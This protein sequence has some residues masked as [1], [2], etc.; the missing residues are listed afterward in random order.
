MAPDSALSHEDI[1]NGA[2]VDQ[3]LERASHVIVPYLMER[4]AEFRELNA[5][6]QAVSLSRLIETYDTDQLCNRD[7]TTP[8]ETSSSRDN[9][10]P[11][12]H[13]MKKRRTTFT[14]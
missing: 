13:V 3:K 4:V 9:A 1:T 8:R 10:K 5:L 11:R 2:G 7:G 6:R 12:M 14:S